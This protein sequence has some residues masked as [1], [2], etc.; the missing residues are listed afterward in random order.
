MPTGSP[1]GLT[2]MFAPKF[3]KNPQGWAQWCEKNRD[4]PELVPGS[5]LVKAHF[6]MS[7]SAF[8]VSASGARKILESFPCHDVGEMKCSPAFDWHLSSLIERDLVNAY[9]P[10]SV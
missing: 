3:G 9:G 4:T 1:D 5:G 2:G 10:Y 7:G 6:F 8:A